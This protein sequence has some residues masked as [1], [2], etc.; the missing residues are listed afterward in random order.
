MEEP[1]TISEI[2]YETLTRASLFLDTVEAFGV[3]YWSGYDDACVNFNEWMER[4][5]IIYDSTF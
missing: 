1:I 5:G 4:E 3:D 2:E